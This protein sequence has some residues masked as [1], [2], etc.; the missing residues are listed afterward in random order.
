MADANKADS[1]FV[2]ADERIYRAFLRLL[3]RYN[4]HEIT[5][6]MIAGEAHVNR[7]TFYAHYRDKFDLLDEVERRVIDELDSIAQASSFALRLYGIGHEDDLRRYFTAIASYYQQQGPVLFALL[8]RGDNVVKAGFESIVEDMLTQAESISELSMPK[9]LAVAGLS[10]MIT[11]IA[12]EWK[13]S[14]CM[15]LEDFVEL[16]IESSSRLVA[17]FYKAPSGA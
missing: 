3:E 15:T 9:N 14:N 13:T 1:R 17:L 16:L 6:S 11:S 7:S 8:E 4:F 12:K 10:G 2:K 5:A